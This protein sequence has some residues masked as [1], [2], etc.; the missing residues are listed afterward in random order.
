LKTAAVLSI[1]RKSSEGA[2]ALWEF[3]DHVNTS[4][5][6]CQFTATHICPTIDKIG[7]AAPSEMNRALVLPLPFALFTSDREFKCMLTEFAFTIKQEIQE[8]NGLPPFTPACKSYSDMDLLVSACK[9][10]VLIELWRQFSTSPE[11]VDLC[12]NKP[13][14][15]LDT[16]IRANLPLNPLRTAA[17][18]AGPLALRNEG[19]IS[20]D[21]ELDDRAAID[22]ITI[23]A[24]RNA[25]FDHEVPELREIV[26][27]LLSVHAGVVYSPKAE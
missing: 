23:S 10:R 11:F 21:S 13:G 2:P 6:L 14:A 7:I 8:N 27:E 1:E 9:S 16:F 18:L 15:A 3:L 20:G 5:E 22:S 4:F 17:L 19:L 12:L 24:T 25:F 26:A